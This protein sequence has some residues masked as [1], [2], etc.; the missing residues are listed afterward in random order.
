MDAIEKHYREKP[1]N[2]IAIKHY[3]NDLLEKEHIL[4]A[5]FFHNQLIINDIKGIEANKL[6]YLIAIKKINQDVSKFDSQLILSNVG[7]EEIYY[8]RLMYYFT[9]GFKEKMLDCVNI[10]IDVDI[11]NIKTF[12]I[13]I[14]SIES[15]ND[16]NITLKFLKYYGKK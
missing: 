5:S 7:K 6:G 1:C 3:V 16:F 8:L 13:L 2:P 11:K 14:E 4:E 10:L 9:F 15:L 12:G